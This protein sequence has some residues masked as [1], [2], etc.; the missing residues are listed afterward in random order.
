MEAT[1]TPV[2]ES[3]GKKARADKADK[4]DKKAASRL[5]TLKAAVDA[6]P[7]L[8]D[9]WTDFVA[10]AIRSG[11][12][13]GARAAFDA[14]LAQ[15]PTS[16]KHWIAYIEFEQQNKA[17]DRVEALF[18]RCL[19]S[20]VSVDIW[21]FY[22]TYIQ[23]V[24]SPSAVPEE[25]RAESRQIVLKAFDL[26]LSN[27]GLD[28]DSG[29]I[30]LEYIAYIKAGTALTKYEE[31]QMM[32]LQRKVY[33]KAL[34]IPLSNIE[35][36]WKD[37]DVFENSLNKLT[38]RKFLSERSAGYMMARTAYRELK[39]ITATIDAM[40]PTWLPTPTKWTETD[41][42][43]LRAWKKY[44]AWEKNNPLRIEDAS[45]LSSRVVYA[46]KSALLMMRF[47]PELWHDAARYLI[48]LG[49]L[50]DA[51]ALLQQAVEALPRSLLLGFAL[52]ELEES[53]KK[54]AAVVSKVYETLITNLESWVSEINAKYD[55]ERDTL[56]ALL[57]KVEIARKRKL[58]QAKEAWSL[59]WIVY[60]R[61]ARR[62]QSVLV[63]RNL[64]KRA[65]KSD[66]C[67]Y[68]VY[69][70]AALMEYYSSKDIKIAC[71]IFEAGMKAFAEDQ[72]NAAG[73][74][75][76][77]LDFL[78]QMNDDNNARAL[79]ERALVLLSPEQARDIWALFFKNEVANGDLSNIL[80]VERRMRDT[81]PGDADSAL[82]IKHLGDRWSF[83]DIQFVA[84]EELGLKG[85]M[86]LHSLDPLHIDAI[87]QPDLSKWTAYKPEA[88][89]KPLLPE[90][91][92]VTAPIPVEPVHKLHQ[93]K[94][95]NPIATLLD[96]LPPASSYNGPQLPLDD[97]VDAL[98]RLPVPTPISTGRMVLFPRVSDSMDRGGS[99]S[100]YDDRDRDRNRDR[101]RERDRERD[102]GGARSG[103]RHVDRY[104]GGGA[105][106][107]KRK[108]GGY[109]SD[110]ERHRKR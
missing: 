86:S 24:H 106:S 92:L 102:R 43:V 21:R 76:H 14:V 70:A 103:G 83:L 32:E 55:H 50:D 62:S 74:I 30:W 35:Q 94:L 107:G 39:I 5:E 22:L 90:K 66:L 31:Q 85:F 46:Y 20:I 69:V 80:K 91:I 89:D 17:F 53:R 28:K 56:M 84:R 29:S 75:V 54:E 77:Y 3:E 96:R 42:E 49:K 15:F 98:T 2:P 23:A 19:R 110:E 16:A 26:V 11:G 105:S 40:Q 6:E 7:W 41:F 34:S 109:G 68:H 63:A 8:V 79:F 88:R 37:Y 100:R 9:A 52:A 59:A 104:V 87:A 38:A 60:M 10:E 1:W 64:F 36:I 12:V 65:R 47:F 25:K 82:G 13:D 73:Y 61:S 67:T 57:K 78:I 108:G 48:E 99:S 72:A 95:P 101:D 44:I 71:N 27:V 81:Y 33:H 45:V 93:F 97:V 58:V 4:A 51:A 18:N